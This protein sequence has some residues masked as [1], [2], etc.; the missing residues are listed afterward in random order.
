MMRPAARLVRHTA[1]P[2]AI[3]LAA[4]PAAAQSAAPPDS[5]A[6]ARA[7]MRAVA[8]DSADAGRRAA[9]S[10]PIPGAAGYAAAAFL[11]GAALGA[12]GPSAVTDHDGPQIA[13][14]VVGVGGLIATGVHAARRT[15]PLPPAMERELAG[16]DSAYARAFR[17]RWNERARARRGK[18]TLLGGL[19]GVLGGIGAVILFITSLDT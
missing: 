7:A 9:E 12:T 1:L 6:A 10:V 14:S 5:L 8:R 18:A 11:S 3:A 15:T 17:A 19:G 4:P 13:L 16:H 2:I